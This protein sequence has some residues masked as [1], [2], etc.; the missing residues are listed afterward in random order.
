MNFWRKKNQILGFSH[1]SIRRCEQITNQKIYRSHVRAATKNEIRRRMC[2]CNNC[3]VSEITGL[4]RW[5]GKYVFLIHY[6]K[7]LKNV[8]H[9]NR[10][11]S[12]SS[13]LCIYVSPGCTVAILDP[14]SR[15]AGIVI[16]KWDFL[17]VSNFLKTE[18]WKIGFA[19]VIDRFQP[20]RKKKMHESRPN[21]RVQ[22]VHLNILGLMHYIERRCPYVSLC[23][24]TKTGCL[25][26][27]SRQKSIAAAAAVIEFF[28]N[29]MI[30]RLTQILIFLHFL[31]ICRVPGQRIKIVLPNFFANF[32]FIVMNFNIIISI[33]WQIDIEFAK[34]GQHLLT[35]IG[36]TQFIGLLDNI[37]LLPTK[38]SLEDVKDKTTRAVMTMMTAMPVRAKKNTSCGGSLLEQIASP[39]LK[40]V[41]VSFNVI[42][43]F[44]VNHSRFFGF[45]LKM[46]SKH[47]RQQISNGSPSWWLQIS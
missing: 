36:E 1:A 29:F 4:R 46:I 14:W 12:R 9:W 21:P 47:L 6:S 11:S 16:S 24:S 8:L 30:F 23:T 33:F 22:N 40:F 35:N 5:N 20:A 18:T 27:Q 10:S 43:V 37:C 25:C 42:N 44:S 38:L 19:P 28:I 7:Y 41:E 15:S 17:H 34:L 45:S 3:I 39:F 2:R 32:L 31:W 26:H 13:V